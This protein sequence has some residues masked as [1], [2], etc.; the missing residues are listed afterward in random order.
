MQLARL[1]AEPDDRID[2]VILRAAV[3]Q[4]FETNGGQARH[5]TDPLALDRIRDKIPAYD[6]YG[7]L[8]HDSSGAWGGDTEYVAM[9]TITG[10]R[11]FTYSE[12]ARGTEAGSLFSERGTGGLTGG[13]HSMRLGDAIYQCVRDG[14]PLRINKHVN[15]NH[16]HAL[17]PVRWDGTP[18]R[19]TCPAPLAR[20]L[21]DAEWR[22]AAAQRIARYDAT[23]RARGAQARPDGRK[24]RG[25]A[26]WWRDK[27]HHA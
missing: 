23:A 26:Q 22:D 6:E 20:V 9:P 27:R 25:D 21:S 2:D 5:G 3:A 15:G 19:L 12:E 11:F 14:V 16:W 4:W 24:R 1:G 18:A 10:A 17:L 8:L 7:R 13:Q